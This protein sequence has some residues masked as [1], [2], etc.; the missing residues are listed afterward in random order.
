M[1][2]TGVISRPA[3]VDDPLPAPHR[4]RAVWL[5]A[6]LVVL[7]AV[8][9]GMLSIAA[10]TLLLA[11]SG[12]EDE[13]GVPAS[14]C[15]QL[16]DTVPVESLTAEQSANARAIIEAGMAAEVP[17]RGLVVAIATAMQESTLRNLNYGDR[18]SLGLFKQRRPWGT[19]AD[20]MDPKTS[21][22]LFFKGG[23]D[24]DGPGPDG[25]EPGLLSI[26]GWQ[27]MSIAEAAQA[28]QRSA[29]PTAYAKW[30]QLATGAVATITGAASAVDCGDGD[31]PLGD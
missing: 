30:E 11:P 9:A 29:F 5:V 3:S 19:A 20:R 21:A 7:F 13:A 15:V 24:L 17:T 16:A 6:G 25:V 2:P 23:R 14:P 12:Q 28:V 1:S 31:E 10:A 22:T 26:R 18:D 4:R 8:P 27:Q